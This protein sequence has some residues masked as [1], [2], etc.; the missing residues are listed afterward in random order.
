VSVHDSASGKQLWSEPTASAAIGLVAI[1]GGDT[2]AYATPARRGSEIVIHSMRAPDVVGRLPV[3]GYLRDFAVSPDGRYVATTSDDNYARLWDLSTGQPAGGPA[4]ELDFTQSMALKFVQFS[5]TGSLLATLRNP[6]RVLI[7]DM[8][9]KPR[10]EVDGVDPELPPSFSSDGRWLLTAGLDDTLRLW[11]AN[12]CKPVSRV[13]LDAELS[14]LSFTP[15]GDGIVAGFDDG[16]LVHWG[17]DARE[18]W[19][20][21]V[22]HQQAVK[23]L[24]FSPADPR[25]LASGSSTGGAHVWSIG[26]AQDPPEDWQ[27]RGWVIALAFS[28]DGTQLTAYS[29]QGTLHG[30]PRG[31]GVESQLGTAACASR[32]ATMTASAALLV[33]GCPQDNTLAVWDV[34]HQRSAFE[35]PL[36]EPARSL[37]ISADGSKVAIS[38]VSGDIELWQLAS[39]GAV[40]QAARLPASQA[41]V[42]SLAFDRLGTALVS[43]GTDATVVVWAVDDLDH[44]RVV[45]TLDVPGMDG[46]RVESVAISA[47]GDL[48][49]AGAKNDGVIELWDANGTTLDHADMSCGD[50]AVSVLQ[51]SPNEQLLAAGCSNGNV[52]IWPIGE[53]AQIEFGCERLARIKSDESLPNICLRTQ[54]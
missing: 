10:C 25:Q 12:T 52:R 46:R 6:Q 16:S 34:A 5:P 30:W 8:D 13:D 32:S 26:A 24:S 21:P 19:Q 44:P 18:W 9:L 20:D 54:G 11:D 22:P 28:D 33:I 41:C 2:I 15:R 47:S 53:A 38:G 48:I 7:T 3:S 23:A 4:L 43:G 40:Q 27:H 36:A 42:T 14:V 37:A 1:P 31:A 49:A 45:A 29:D 17:L 51:F 35:V 39:D 50:A